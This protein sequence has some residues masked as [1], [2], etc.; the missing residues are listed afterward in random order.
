[1][2]SVVLRMQEVNRG[3]KSR[4]LFVVRHT[5]MPA[6]LVEGGFLSN[7]IENQLLRNDGYRDRLAQGIAVGVL[8]YIQGTQSHVAPHLAMS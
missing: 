7:K 4:N 5:R 3:I 6:I 2:A 1:M 8:T